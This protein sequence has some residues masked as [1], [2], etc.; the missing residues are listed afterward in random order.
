VDSLSRNAG[1]AYMV[2]IALLLTVHAATHCC[3]YEIVKD[4]LW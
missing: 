3:G 1:I 4:D 2:Q